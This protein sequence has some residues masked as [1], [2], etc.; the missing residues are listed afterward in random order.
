MY[1]SKKGCLPFSRSAMKNKDLRIV[2]KGKLFTNHGAKL[3]EQKIK[4]KRENENPE[5]KRKT[6]AKK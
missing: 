2:Q 6:D 3:V 1:C 5:K 4:K